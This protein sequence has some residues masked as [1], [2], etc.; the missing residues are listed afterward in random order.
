[1]LF[2]F[3]FGSISGCHFDRLGQ[4]VIVAIG[5]GMR[6]EAAGLG[7]DDMPGEIQHLVIHLDVGNGLEGGLGRADLVVEIE[8][9][10]DDARTE[11]P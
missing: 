9:V 5:I 8:R 2:Y 11:R 6:I 10:G 1:M 4:R 3:N 7:R